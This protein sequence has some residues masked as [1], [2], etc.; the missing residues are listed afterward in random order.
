MPVETF[1][2]SPILTARRYNEFKTKL[3][4]SGCPLCPALCA[5]RHNIV[6]DRGNPRAEIVI[7][8]EAPGETEDL[9]GKAFVGRS[10]QLLDKMLAMV[11]IDTNHD[12]LIVNIAKCR[13]PDNR[14]PTPVEAQNCRP[15]L[16]KQLNFVKP[17]VVLLLGATAVKHL[18]PE[19]KNK[20]MKDRVGQFSSTKAFPG[21]SFQ[22]L[23]HPAYLLR[24]PRKKADML[25]HLKALRAFL[26]A[27]KKEARHETA[28]T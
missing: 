25:E 2:R 6:V 5:N 13:P 22:L 12:V 27:R 15:Y 14:R 23:Y 10:G 8:G 26:D 28:H 16:E 3:A 11:G 24:D 18:M 21:V 20:N 7:V 9:Q 17:S 19:V 1:D 4:S